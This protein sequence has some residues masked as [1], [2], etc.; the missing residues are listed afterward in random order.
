[1]RHP[2]RIL[3]VVTG[4]MPG[5]VQVDVARSLLENWSDM[6]GWLESL[7]DFIILSF[8]RWD[9]LRIGGTQIQWLVIISMIIIE[10]G[11]S[12]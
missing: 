7:H 5:Q 10:K 6:K 9:C 1:M 12:K 11:N 4:V 3:N 8:L 2:L